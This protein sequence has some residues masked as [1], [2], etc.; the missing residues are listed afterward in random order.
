M[1]PIAAATG[2]PALGTWRTVRRPQLEAAAR[3]AAAARDGVEADLLTRAHVLVLA[4]EFQGFFT[5]LL[6]EI[7]GAL[8]SALPAEVPPDLREVLREAMEDGRVVGFRNP[9][10]TTLGRDLIRFDIRLRDLL[11]RGDRTAAGLLARLEQVIRVRN[12]LAHGA[13]PVSE[14][15]PGGGRLDPRTVA[16]WARD[17]DRLATILDNAVAAHLSAHLSVTLRREEPA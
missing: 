3:L 5:D 2:S 11:A 17:L 14:V 1:E 12:K 7:T 10:A 15:G 16:E 8:V 13:V 6:S 4:A 9:D